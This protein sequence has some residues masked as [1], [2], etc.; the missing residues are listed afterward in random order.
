MRLWTIR[1]ATW[2]LLLLWI[3]VMMVV[4]ESPGVASIGA[5]AILLLSALLRRALAWRAG[6]VLWAMGALLVIF[7]L[8]DLGG[9]DRGIPLFAV[10]LIGFGSLM[11]VRA[12][13]TPWWQRSGAVVR[14][15][16]EP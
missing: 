13:S 10:A 16:P 9:D 5:G 7:G 8:N 11:L 14:R 4:E 15:P 3:G 2:G 1:R 12:F 6:F